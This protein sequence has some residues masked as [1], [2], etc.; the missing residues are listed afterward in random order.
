MSPSCPKTWMPEISHSVCYPI[1][2]KFPEPGRIQSLLYIRHFSTNILLL[3][4]LGVFMC[5]FPFVRQTHS[6]QKL[7]PRT[8]SLHLDHSFLR[9][10]H[11][12][13]L[14]TE[15][16]FDTANSCNSTFVSW[17]CFVHTVTMARGVVSHP[18]WVPSLPSSTNFCQDRFSLLS[19]T[20][21]SAVPLIDK[22]CVKN[23]C[24]RIFQP[25]NKSL[26]GSGKSLEML[27]LTTSYVIQGARKGV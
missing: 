5:R 3:D 27:S 12:P 4:L 17:Y 25:L 11:H 6:P 24:W 8:A 15:I 13:K 1:I 9:D 26:V 18:I 22:I 10:G 16:N 19:Q 23:V 2:T 20:W 14:V 7:A 21:Y